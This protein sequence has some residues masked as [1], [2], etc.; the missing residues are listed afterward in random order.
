M[1]ADVWEKDVWEFWEFR[2]FFFFRSFP[3]FLRENRNSKNV[4][5]NTWKWLRQNV[6]LPKPG[7]GWGERLTRPGNA[8]PQEANSP[9][10]PPKFSSSQRAPTTLLLQ[11]KQTSLSLSL[12]I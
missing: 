3:S 10:H 8:A 9:P 11:P 4:W 7:L 2:F 12:Y 1:V 6:F 5:E